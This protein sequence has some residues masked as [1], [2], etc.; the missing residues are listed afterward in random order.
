M[1]RLLPR[2]SQAAVESVRVGL[3]PASPD[4]LPII[5]PLP[6]APRLVMATGHFRNGVLLAPLTAEL[7]SRYLVD[8]LTD[9]AIAATTPSRFTASAG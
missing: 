7:V 4:G 8:G 1:A 5:G 3:R 9:P 2:A 6:G